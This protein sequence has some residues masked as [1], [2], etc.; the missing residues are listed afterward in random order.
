MFG[1]KK[2]ST[3]LW[4]VVG[5][6]QAVLF[7]C[8]S[9][10]SP[11]SLFREIFETY[12]GNLFGE[13]YSTQYSTSPTQF[14]HNSSVLVHCKIWCKSTVILR[15]HHSE[16]EAR[17]TIKNDRTSLDCC[18]KAGFEQQ[19]NSTSFIRHTS[20]IILFFV[21]DNALQIKELLAVQ[22][23]LEREISKP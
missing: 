6:R 21:H 14:V 4:S 22:Y 11:N 19:V 10:R 23:A 18:P 9:P 16:A 7:G 8:F 20:L 5:G 12:F 15:P 13:P 1:R 2:P 17:T 3:Q